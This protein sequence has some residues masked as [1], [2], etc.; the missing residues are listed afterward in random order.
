MGNE[1]IVRMLVSKGANV[2]TKAE[3]GATPIYIAS[4]N[5]HEKVVRFLI[6]C[7]ADMECVF[8]YDIKLD[9]EIDFLAI[10][11]NLFILQIVEDTKLL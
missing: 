2:N 3:R 8:K 7:G 11:T 6:E 10:V 1:E 4:Q 9:S 5:G